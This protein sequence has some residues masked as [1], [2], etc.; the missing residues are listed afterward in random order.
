MNKAPSL[1]RKLG[2]K[3]GQQVAL[4]N[5]PDGFAAIIGEEN[6]RQGILVSPGDSELDLA[7]L[8]VLS[9]KEL[10]RQFPMLADGL[11][12]A[13]MLWV[14][15]PKKSSGVE[16]DLTFDVVQRTGLACGLVDTKICA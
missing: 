3:P 9:D 7:L 5:P 14:A 8:F 10:G 15:W 11:S 4:V 6:L 1:A 16:T 2:L 12:K 13:G